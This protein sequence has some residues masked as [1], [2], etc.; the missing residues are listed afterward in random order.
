[1]TKANNVLKPALILTAICLVVALALALTYA[2]TKDKID[3]GKSGTVNEANLKVMPDADDFAEKETADGEKYLEALDKQD[4]VIGYVFDTEAQGYAAKIV[5]K[6]GITKDG[7]IKGIEYVEINDSPNQTAAAKEDAFKNQFKKKIP[8]NKFEVVTGTATKDE[9][10]QAI[11]GGTGTSRGVVEAVNKAVDLFNKVTGKGGQGQEEDLNI[12]VLP[13]AKEFSEKTTDDGVKY[14]AGLDS[15]G[16]V[17]GYVFETDGQGYKDVI[18]VKVGISTDGVIQGVEIVEINDSK[19]QSAGAKEDSFKDQFKKKIPENPFVVVNEA[20][21]K[22][23][24]IQAIT[25]GTM[26]SRGV[27]AAVNKAVEFFNKVTG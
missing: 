10:I 24:E 20:P 12:K 26:T 15:A 17:I 22:D 7:E 2:L 16:N 5:I 11:T 25:S 8:A 3:S 13:D 9:E 18:K 14:L 1:M 4:N 19:N 6:T 21:A 23:E 27:A